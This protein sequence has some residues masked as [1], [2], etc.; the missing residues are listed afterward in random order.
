MNKLGAGRGGG[1]GRGGDS[2]LYIIDR[3]TDGQTNEQ[4]HIEQSLN[5]TNK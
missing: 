4:R 3:P 1:G 2:T 5:K